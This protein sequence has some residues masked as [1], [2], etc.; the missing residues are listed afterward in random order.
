MWEIVILFESIITWLG[1]FGVMLG[2]KWSGLEMS[3]QWPKPE[4]SP[5]EA[6]SYMDSFHIPFLLG[7]AKKIKSTN[8]P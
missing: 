8:D 7:P 4:M 5:L 2:S 6:I 1:R 3:L